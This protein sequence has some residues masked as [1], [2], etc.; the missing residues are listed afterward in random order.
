MKLINI[1]AVVL[2]LVGGEAMTQ[3]EAKLIREGNKQFEKGNFQEAEISYKKALDTDQESLRAGFNLGDAI[4]EQ[5]NYTES[6]KKFM[7][8]SERAKD[9]DVRAGSYHNLGNALLKEKKYAESIEAYKKALKINPDEPD[10]KYN[11]QYAKTMLKKQQ[12]Q[13]QQQQNKDQNKQDQQNKD[14]KDQK[15]QQEQQKQD[16]QQEQQQKQDQQEQQQQQQQ[17]Q[18]QGQEEEQQQKEQQ[19]KQQPL[20]ISKEDAQRM[21]DALSNEEKETLK[22][23]I[24]K[25]IKAQGSKAKEKDW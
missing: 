19:Q 20:K 21:L 8:I 23:L 7:E 11:L 14:Q 16:Q 2:I 9:E 24:E 22:K 5:E 25:R 15:D 17:Q 18:Q 4:Y 3:N 6:G 10:T 13:Q 12:Q 1:Y